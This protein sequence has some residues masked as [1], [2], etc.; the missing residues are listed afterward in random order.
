MGGFNLKFGEYKKIDVTEE[1]FWK[2]FNKVFSTKT[3]NSSSYKFVFLKSLLDCIYIYKKIKYSFYEIFER[4]TEIYWVLVVKY[5]LAQNNST[6]KETYIEQILNE[7]VECTTDKYPIKME[8]N[9]LTENVKK[10]IVCQVTQKCKTYVV[11]ALYYD[12]N[13]LFYSFSKKDEILEINPRM[14]KFIEKYGSLIEELNYYEL[15]KFLDKVNSR[16]TVEHI[17]NKKPTYKLNA[18][19]AVYRQLLY[20]EFECERSINKKFCEVNTMELLMEVED[21]LKNK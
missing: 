17:L 14:L 12:T 5:G 21:K 7:Y 1:E 10:K 16:E 4:F 9:D 15:T 13:E 20:D 19:Q 2:A 18:E 8:F 3:V 6:T 11:G